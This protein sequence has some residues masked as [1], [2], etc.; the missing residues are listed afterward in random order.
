MRK[1]TLLH[2]LSPRFCA[3]GLSVLGLLIGQSV[4]AQL[5]MPPQAGYASIMPI[6]DGEV[7]TAWSTTP[8]IPIALPV[9]TAEAGTVAVPTDVVA[10]YS[11]MYDAS[12]LYLL[13]EV[14]EDNV[15]QWGNG[16][17]M[18]DGV[19]IY[20]D[21]DLS[22]GMT[23]DGVNDTQIGILPT[24]PANTVYFGA[25]SIQSLEGITTGVVSSATSY[26][27]EVMIPWSSLG[28]DPMAISAIG[29]EVAVNDGDPNE[30]NW[31]PARVGWVSDGNDASNVPS[32]F[33]T[34]PLEEAGL[35]AF[36]ILVGASPT[37]NGSL[38]S[39]WF[40]TYIESSDDWILHSEAGWLYVGFVASTDGLWLWSHRLQSWLWSSDG[41][42]PVYYQYPD[43]RWITYF[44]FED[45]TGFLFD[46]TN[47]LWV[48]LP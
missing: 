8:Q 9:K 43:N 15:T 18:D 26:A 21:P 37:G 12:N 20:L 39:P 5:A 40:G 7:D 11:A 33:G 17:F 16:W 41:Q 48:T 29:I 14:A 13:V 6:I 27:I 2:K 30:G 31:P 19:E 34:L 38:H 42:F 36:S 4:H 35:S 25:S 23:Y 47:R 24:D 1:I 10:S 3:V 28:V 22:G 45:G 44:V 46:F 32:V